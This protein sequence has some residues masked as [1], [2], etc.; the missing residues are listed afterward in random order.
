ML[1]RNNV[2]LYGGAGTGK[3]YSARTISKLLDWNLITVN[4]N[5]FT[6]A[7]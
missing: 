4:C 1:A 3:T 6:S 7:L 5:Q 2:Y